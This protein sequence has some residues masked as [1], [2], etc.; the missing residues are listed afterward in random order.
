MTHEQ[1]TPNAICQS[2]GMGGFDEPGLSLPTL[3]VLLKPSFSPE[4]CITLSGTDPILSVVAAT[5]MLSH[6]LYPCAMGTY[7]ERVSIS[8]E[9]ATQMIADF[10]AVLAANRDE[11][12]RMVCIA[13]GMPCVLMLATEAGT[14]RMEC[15]AF[16][17][18]EEAFISSLIRVAWESC[19]NAGV[20]NTLADCGRYVGLKLPRETVTPL[21]KLF[22]IAVVG[23][24]DAKAD[25][26]RQ[27][28]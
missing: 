12:G 2:L 15:H 7:R 20:R 4:V 27:C 25:L 1:Y 21:P 24:P 10:D 23:T 17:S 19:H 13:D 5:E 6:Q 9:I 26:L 3:R 18:V 16:L 8:A 22:R 28:Q 14:N 11:V